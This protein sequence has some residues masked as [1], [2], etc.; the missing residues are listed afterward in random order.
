MSHLINRAPGY[1][2][3]LLIVFTM[4]VSIKGCTHHPKVGWQTLVDPTETD[5]SLW[6]EEGIIEWPN[7]PILVRVEPTDL[8]YPLILSSTEVGVVFW[9]L[10]V[11]CTIFEVTPRVGDVQVSMQP[12]PKTRSSW[13]ASAT[14]FYVG[15]PLYKIDVY[16]L[17]LNDRE[18]NNRVMAH[19]LGHVLGMRDLHEGVDQIMYQFMRGGG[20]ADPEV[21]KYLNKMYC[22]D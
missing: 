21:V 12:R 2:L 8:M 16:E 1:A 17:R 4:G 22:K 13:I 18:F 20:L 3:L 15:R 19:E 14:P 9:N 10:A 7:T 5:Q 11:G 6:H